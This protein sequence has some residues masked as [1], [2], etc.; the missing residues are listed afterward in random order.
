MKLMSITYTDCQIMWSCC[1]MC[2][3]ITNI[4]DDLANCC[5]VIQYSVPHIYAGLDFA[6]VLVLNLIA[7]AVRSFL[8]EELTLM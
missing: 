4:D 6:I 3:L 2:A 7:R 1:N 5:K 8:T